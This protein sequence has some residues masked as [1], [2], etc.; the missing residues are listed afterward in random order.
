METT[1]GLID[2]T[3]TTTLNHAVVVGRDE[4]GDTDRNTNTNT[5]N[6]NV[7]LSGAATAVATSDPLPL[8]TT[9][10][11]FEGCFVGFC[12]ARALIQPQ[13]LKR[14]SRLTSST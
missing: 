9:F 3:T 11:G 14:N 13:A 5:N 1:F 2:V 7:V 4:V 8:P 12:D 10:S 6:N